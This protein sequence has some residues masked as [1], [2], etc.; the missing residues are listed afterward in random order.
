MGTSKLV[1]GIKSIKTKK[2]TVSVT[3][4]EIENVIL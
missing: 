1:G 4:I 3:S 2:K